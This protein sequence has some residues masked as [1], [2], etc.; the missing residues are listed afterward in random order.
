MKLHKAYLDACC[1]VIL[2]V[3]IPVCALLKLRHMTKMIQ[4]AMHFM[5]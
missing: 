5:V 2:E 3:F 1:Q 4:L